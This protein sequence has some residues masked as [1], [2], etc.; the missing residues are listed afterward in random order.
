VLKNLPHPSVDYEDIDDLV[1]PECG[2]RYNGPHDDYRQCIRLLQLVSKDL[3][4]QIKTLE[5]SDLK[6]PVNSRR[7]RVVIFRGRAVYLQEA[8]A[9]LGVSR[10]ALTKRIHRSGFT[11]SQDLMDL[12]P[13][14]GKKEK[15]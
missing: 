4:F 2:V 8:A 13:V 6:P 14:Q 15:D 7:P 1:C 10:L 12:P 11:P 9:A 5:T 3:M